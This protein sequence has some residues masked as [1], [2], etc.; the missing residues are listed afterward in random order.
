VLASSKDWNITIWDLA[1]DH[2]PPLPLTT[3]RFDAS[4]RFAAL[5]PRNRCV[6][7]LVGDSYANPCHSKIILAL[8]ETGDAYV[9]DTRKEYRGRTELVEVLEM[10]DDDSDEAPRCAL[11]ALLAPSWTLIRIPCRP[12]A[13]MTAAAFDPTG[14]YIFIGTA[15]ASILVF[16]TRTKMVRSHVVSC[17]TLSSNTSSQMLARHRIVGAGTIKALDLAPPSVPGN[18][19]RLMTNS[20]DRVLREFIIPSSYPIPPPSD[21]PLPV[22]TL[23]LEIVNRYSDPITRTA[24]TG[25][26]LKPVGTLLAGA[27]QSTHKIYIWDTRD[28]RFVTTLDGG[29]EALA[30]VH[31]SFVDTRRCS[32]LRNA[33]V[34]P[35][36]TQHCLRHEAWKYP[37]L[38]CASTR[39]MGCVRRGVRG[40]RRER[41]VRG[42]RGRV[43]PR[44]SSKLLFLR[45]RSLTQAI[46]GGRRRSGKKEGGS[47]G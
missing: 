20:S 40:G 14:R 21:L 36:E 38:A 47:R 10:P 19:A 25:M 41:V 46:P 7:N 29:R 23:E 42:A 1:S 5:H 35:N 15:D 45:T 3:I 8:M 44:A 33:T 11:V 27:D 13:P 16:S 6:L 26:S 37:D 32:R 34:A 39:A 43:R 9:V 28:G 22:P 18:R 2:D 31:V 4:V 24:W 30:D 17:H 12:P